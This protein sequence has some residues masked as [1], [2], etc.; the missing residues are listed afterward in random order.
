MAG[1]GG[2]PP[3]G[4]GDG[5]DGEQPCYPLHWSPSRQLLEELI[6]AEVKIAG[7]DNKG[8]AGVSQ[9]REWGRKGTGPLVRSRRCREHGHD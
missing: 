1:D 5:E 6:K 4:E 3:P 7:T 2:P 9:V 8:A